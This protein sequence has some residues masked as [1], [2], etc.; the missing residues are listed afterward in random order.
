MK[1]FIL[2]LLLL[3]STSFAFGQGINF[4]DITIEQAL[5]E[6]KNEGKY[7]FIDF[8]TAW[9]GPCK[10]MEKQ[11]FPLKQMGDYFNPKYVCLKLNA[12]DGEN[13]KQAAAKFNVKAYPT[14]V[15]L[16]SDGELVHMFAGGVLDLT[17]IDK[18]EEAFDSSKAYGVLKKCYDAG[19]R[20][21]HFLASYLEALQNT[22]TVGNMTELIEQFYNTLSDQDKISAECLFL[23]DNYAPIGS[24]REKFLTEH[25]EDFRKVAGSEK[26][27]EIFKRKYIAYYGQII[28]GYNPSV[29]L[30]S[31]EAINKRMGSLGLPANSVYQLYQTAA[32]VKITNEG[33]DDLFRLILNVKSE[34]SQTD[35]DTCLYYV[36]I[37]LKEQFSNEQQKELL[38]YISDETT[39]GY[40]E[41]SIK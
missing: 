41:R 11:I 37:G 29:V 18:V 25:K 2:T 28:M 39:R 31:I 6:A 40:V 19:E 12:E 21:P 34:L 36:I 23:F 27:N 35:L 4:R 16:D 32:M 38:A 22:Y 24:E 26:V 13:G 14:F 15:I 9:C 1:G 20:D 3:V 33:V 17:F 7:V 5:Q 10:L 30:E 8:Y